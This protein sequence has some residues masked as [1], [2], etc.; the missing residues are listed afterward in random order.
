[1]PCGVG[2]KEAAAASREAEPKLQTC[3][4]NKKTVVA[5]RMAALTLSQTAA[6]R[7]QL[8]FLQG[9]LRGGCSGQQGGRRQAAD[10]LRQ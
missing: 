6:S 1:M 10:V 7:T 9:T 3:H 4:A 5:E 8:S 2:Y